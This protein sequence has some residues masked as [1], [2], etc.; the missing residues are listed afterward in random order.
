MSDPVVRNTNGF[1]GLESLRRRRL[2]IFLSLL[3]AS[4][5]SF[6]RIESSFNWLAVI[7]IG[8]MCVWPKREKSATVQS[9]IAPHDLL[10]QGDEIIFRVKYLVMVAVSVCAL[11]VYLR[12]AVNAGATIGFSGVSAW[13]L[14]DCFRTQQAKH[15][16][17]VAELLGKLDDK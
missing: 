12:I 5:N 15:D 9:G 14:V 3:M 8:I 11:L 7:C 1:Y 17:Y 6:F 2:G 4:A 10:E 13:L 16:A